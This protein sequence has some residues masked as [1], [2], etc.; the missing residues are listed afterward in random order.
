[1]PYICARMPAFFTSNVGGLTGIPNLNFY[2]KSSALG[3][4]YFRDNSVTSP[5]MEGPRPGLVI[6]CGWIAAILPFVGGYTQVTT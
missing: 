1:M 5:S 2:F 6:I 4:P 3:F